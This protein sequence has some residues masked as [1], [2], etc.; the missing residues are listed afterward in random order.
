MSVPMEVSMQNPNVGDDNNNNTSESEV[1]VHHNGVGATEPPSPPNPS[2]ILTERKYLVS[3]FSR[4]VRYDRISVI[5]NNFVLQK[6]VS[7]SFSVFVSLSF[8]ELCS[9]GV[10][11]AV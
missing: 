2:P 5:C 7:F 11:E 8:S 10:L 6:D 1:A 3:G 9:W 4:K